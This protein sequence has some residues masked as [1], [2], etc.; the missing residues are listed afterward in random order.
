MRKQGFYERYIKRPQ[1]VLCALLALFFFIPCTFGYGSAGA[2]QAG[3]SG[4]F[5]TETAWKR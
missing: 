3:K 4:D 2:N 5:Q 1:D